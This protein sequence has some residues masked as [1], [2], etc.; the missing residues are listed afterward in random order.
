MNERYGTGNYIQEILDGRT[1]GEYSQQKATAFPDNHL[2]SLFLEDCL[3]ITC[4]NGVVQHRYG[5]SKI[6]HPPF[7]LGAAL[8]FPNSSESNSQK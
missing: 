3:F 7:V 1:D 8:P 5:N 6:I 4:N 2:N